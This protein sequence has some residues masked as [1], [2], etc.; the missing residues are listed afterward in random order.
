MNQDFDKAILNHKEVA[1]AFLSL[2]AEGKVREAYLRYIGPGFRH[3]NTFF[4][5]DAGSLIAAME[6]NVVQ[7]PSKVL[8]VKHALQEGDFVAVHSHV[9]LKPTDPGLALVHIF[10]FQ[11]KLIAELWDI[12]QPVPE[13]SPNEYGMF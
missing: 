7:N 2:V 12:A 1:V 8:E 6:E 10:R 3:H 11:G 13:N 4:K 5:G 9:R